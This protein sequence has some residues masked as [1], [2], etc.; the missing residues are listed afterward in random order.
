MSVC[1]V[2][3]GSNDDDDKDFNYPTSSVG[4]SSN[5]GL[6][7]QK[8]DYLYFVNG[9]QNVDSMKEQ[10]TKYTLGALMIAKL[11]ENGNVI[12]EENGSLDYD[13]YNYMSKRLCGFEATNLFIGGDYLYFTSPCE[14][15]ESEGSSSDPVWAKDRVE[16]YRIKLDKSGEI[17]RVYQ[18]N[19]KYSEIDFE[20]Y[21]INGNTYIL[22]YEGGKSLD[23]DATDTLIRVSANNKTETVVKENVLSY[24]MAENSNEIFYSFKTTKN[25]NTFYQLNQYNLVEN[26]STEFTAKDVDFDI[27]AVKGGKVFISYQSTE[28]VTSTDLYMATISP[29]TAFPTV[30]PDV[31]NLQSYDKYY[32]TDDGDFFIGVKGNKIKVEKI[33]SSTQ[34]N[35]V[36]DAAA[37]SITVVGFVNGKIVYIDNNNMI[38]SFSYYNYANGVAEQ[39][40]TLS[41]VEGVDTT[42][43]DLDENYVYF[44][45]TVGSN[46]YLHRVSLNATYVEE[47][48]NDQMIGVYLDADIP[49]IEE[50][51]E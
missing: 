37:E 10:N 25:G 45:K 1:L 26:K 47:E 5:G 8:G 21:Y 14:E 17:E 28:L 39:I 36:I 2:A 3:C 24:V 9:F 29:K 20:Y 48:T 4:T 23:S 7:V 15:N 19:V 12:T 33:G 42:Y 35:K 46:K 16:F 6:A 49:E 34:L 43:L 51:E 38:K 44:Y 31:T 22:V 13:Y 30:I 11:D 41:K 18:S 32:I 40:K 27:Q 50:K